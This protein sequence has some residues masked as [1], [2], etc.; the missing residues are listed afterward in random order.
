VKL[1]LTEDAQADLVNIRI[2][3]TKEF[4]GQ[5]TKSYMEKLRQGFKTLRQHPE[6]GY[7]IDHLKS[8]YRCFQ[9]EYHRVFYK[10]DNEVIAVVA[11]LHESQLPKRHLERRKKN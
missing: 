4:G 5:Q 8:G 11:V 2:Y 3:T 10:F 7:G 1:R 9:I 6:I